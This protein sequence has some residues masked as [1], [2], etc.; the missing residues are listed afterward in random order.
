MATETLS[1]SLTV[2]IIAKRDQLLELIRSYE[3]C[4]VALSAGVDSAV[5]AKAAFLALGARAVAVTGVSASLA[6][7]ELDEARAVA[8]CIGIRHEIIHTGELENP[9]YT[10]NAPDRCFHCKTELYGQMKHVAER[11]NL[12][13]LVGGANADDAADYRPGMTAAEAAAVRSPLLECGVTKAEVRMLAAH[14]SLPVWDK[15]ATPCLSSRVAYGEQVTPERLAQIDR[16]EQVLR[17]NGLRT[18]RV[19]VH[20]GDLARLEVPLDA[21]AGLCVADT[22][23]AVVRELKELGFKYVVLDLE[24]FRSGSQNLVLPL[25]IRF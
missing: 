6:E 11:L 12:A 18:V 7:G 13:V 22:R 8:A 17:A 16:A 10:Q 15:P 14:W 23:Q 20:K 2:K 4:A 1:P 19:R 21:L 24:G 5:V 25:P 9:S 3:S